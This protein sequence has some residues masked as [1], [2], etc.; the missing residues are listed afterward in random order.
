[1]VEQVDAANI[2]RD[3]FI[4]HRVGCVGVGPWL[5]GGVCHQLVPD[6]GAVFF[7]IAFAPFQP[8]EKG[9]GN[10]V[11][12]GSLGVDPSKGADF[13]EDEAPAFDAVDNGETA[14]FVTRFA[15]KNGRLVFEGRIERVEGL[16][17][18]SEGLIKRMEMQ[19]VGEMDV[20]DLELEADDLLER[21]RGV[22]VK[23]LCP[24]EE[25]HTGQEANQ[26]K[27][28]I[29]V[30]MRNKDMVDLAA[31][32]FV[33]GHLHLGPFA[34]IDQKDMVFHGDYLCSRMTIKSR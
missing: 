1:M 16:I 18:R 34:A 33:F 32:D 8:I 15:E 3:T 22:D 27:V 21:G 25:P 30:Q 31:A 4:E 24:A 26:A 14:D 2:D 9:G 11:L 5:A 19:P 13:A 23:I 20:G 7:L 28:V 6:D 17:E 10:V 29:A 12:P